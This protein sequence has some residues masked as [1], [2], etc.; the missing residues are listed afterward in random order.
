MNQC[1]VK[2]AIQRQVNESQG[3]VCHLV[4]DIQARLITHGEKEKMQYKFTTDSI[5]MLSTL[6]RKIIADIE[7]RSFAGGNRTAAGRTLKSFQNLSSKNAILRDSLKYLCTDEGLVKFYHF[8]SQYDA[9]FFDANQQ[10][11]KKIILLY[12]MIAGLPSGGSPHFAILEQI[13]FE[14]NAFSIRQPLMRL[15]GM[16]Q[17]FFGKPNCVP[18][19]L[20]IDYSKS[21]IKAI[22]SY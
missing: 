21:M 14:Y 8:V 4:G 11:E 2:I 15:K 18:K 22:K 12:A 16:E 20:I 19:L 7:N 3:D 9:L 13:T 1:S 17:K 5:W 6:F 10:G